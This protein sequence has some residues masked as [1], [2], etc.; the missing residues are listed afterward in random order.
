MFLDLLFSL[1]FLVALVGWIA[2]AV[3]PLR[4]G[5]LLRIGG[6]VVPVILSVGYVLLAA[7]YFPDASGGLTSLPEA[8]VFFTAPGVLLAGWVHYLAFDL[9][10]GAWAVRDA[11][12]RGVPHLA[13][14]PCLVLT[15]MLGPVGFLAYMA[16][17]AIFARRGATA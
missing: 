3:A 5:L 11:R 15:M 9:V 16:V 8:L 4:P 12:T 14:L 1:S 10:V 13:V 2:L 17:R 6:R 7:T